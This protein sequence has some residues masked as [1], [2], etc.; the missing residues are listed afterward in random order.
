MI[1]SPPDSC[2]KLYDKHMIIERNR[3]TIKKLHSEEENYSSSLSIIMSKS[4]S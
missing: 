4:D 2:E 3:I 1:D